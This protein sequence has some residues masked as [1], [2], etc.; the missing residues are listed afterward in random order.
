FKI[1]LSLTYQPT[2]IVVDFNNNGSL[3]G[4]STFTYTPSGSPG[5]DSTYISNGKTYYLYRIPQVYTFNASGTY[6]V[7]LTTTS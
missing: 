7:K 4:P 5:Y 3:V 6:P 1:N 2:Q